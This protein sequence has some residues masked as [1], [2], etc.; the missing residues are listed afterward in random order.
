MNKDEMNNLMK[1]NGKNSGIDIG[2]MKQAADSGKLDDYINQNLSKDM[3]NR[4]KDVLSDKSKTEKL[5]SSPEA[6]ELMK[7]LGM[8]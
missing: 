5:L 7:K 6:Q 2:K 3:T 8:K 4:L 1:K